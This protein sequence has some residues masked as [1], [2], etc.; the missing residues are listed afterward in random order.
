MAEIQERLTH[1][2]D[3]GSLSTINAKRLAAFERFFNNMEKKAIAKATSG[4]GSRGRSIH[5][6]FIESK[7]KRDK[8]KKLFLC[9]STLK[10]M[11]S[12]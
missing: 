10:L 7:F 4:C 9:C 2:Y 3:E 11:L 12:T 6:N 5:G 8:P 1:I